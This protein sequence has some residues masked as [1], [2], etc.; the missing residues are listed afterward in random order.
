MIVIFFCFIC[1]CSEDMIK[2]KMDSA[3]E[4]QSFWLDARIA[5]KTYLVTYSQEN[6]IFF[7]LVKVSGRV[8]QVPSLKDQ[9][10][11]KCFIGPAAWRATG[12]DHYHCSVKLSGS[13]HWK[14]VKHTL[15]KETRS[16][17]IFQMLAITTGTHSNI[18][19]KVTQIFSLVPIIL[20]CK[21]W[22]LQKLKYVCRPSG[23]NLNLGP[24]VIKS[25]PQQS[26]VKQHVSV[27]WKFQIHGSHQ[28][29]L[30]QILGLFRTFFHFF[31]DFLHR[32]PSTFPGLPTKFQGFPG[33][34]RSCTNSKNKS[35]FL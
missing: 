25:Q 35:Y 20:T 5:R 11:L 27:T 34:L 30:I 26:H 32:S 10:N 33:L 18:S 14:A 9:V 28:K 23:K 7:Q 21:I 31:Q 19:P 1:L 17:C 3:N 13:K 2:K 24:Q 4:F 8:L 12:G 16:T 6:R 22:N 15:K 29:K